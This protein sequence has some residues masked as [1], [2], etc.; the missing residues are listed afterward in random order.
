MIVYNID[1]KLKAMIGKVAYWI[2]GFGQF[3]RSRSR[4]SMCT[5]TEKK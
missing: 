2:G 4:N 3:G 5:R 1:A